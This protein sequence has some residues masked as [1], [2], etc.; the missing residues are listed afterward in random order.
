MIGQI[1]RFGVV[2]ALATGVHMLIGLMLIG[3]GWAALVAN[4][5]AFVT[6]FSV[7][8]IGHIGYSFADQEADLATAAWRFG[9]VA[10]AGFCINEAVL[11]FLLRHA[12][13]NGME[14]LCLSTGCAALLTFA[15]SKYWAFHAHRPSLP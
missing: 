11:A 3:S 13:L 7:S 14:A 5:F 8:L 1:M 6:A 12:A 10:V 2:G 15:A 4:G 9:I